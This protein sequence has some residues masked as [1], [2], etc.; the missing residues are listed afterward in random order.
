MKQAG[1]TVIAHGPGARS[2][3]VGVRCR[4]LLAGASCVLDSEETDFGVEL[5][6]NLTSALKQ[7]T[8]EVIE[9]ERNRAL[10]KTFGIEEESPAI[11]ETFRQA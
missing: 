6:R 1:L 9:K 8:S 2:W 3:P 7:K 5:Q 10:M 4:A 11:E